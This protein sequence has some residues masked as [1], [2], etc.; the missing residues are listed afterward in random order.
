[1]I[2]S[3]VAKLIDSGFIKK[4]QHLD[5]VANIVP[6]TKKNGKIQVCIDFRDRNQA[7]PKD[8]FSLPIT[9]V[10]INNKCGFERMSFD[11]LDTIKLRCTLMMRNIHHSE[12]H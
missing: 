12:H 6:I 11:S 4:E 1:M 8:E 3:E 7:Y 5:C 9:D 10:M 2:Q